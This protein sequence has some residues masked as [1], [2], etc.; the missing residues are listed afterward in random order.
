MFWSADMA[1]FRQFQI[2]ENNSVGS[3]GALS[4]IERNGT[5]STIYSAPRVSHGYNF[6]EGSHTDPITW[7]DLF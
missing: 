1:A 7:N 6:I 5:V 2:I 4:I 3:E